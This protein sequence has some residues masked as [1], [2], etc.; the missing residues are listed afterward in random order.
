MRMVSRTTDQKGFTLIE[1]LIV[2]AIIGFLAAAVLVAVDPVKRIQDS[3]D[4]RRFSEANALLNAILTKQVDERSLLAGLAT[5][6]LIT[7]ST[8]A[9]VIVTDSTGIVCNAAAT[10]PGCNKTLDT[11][12]ANKNCVANIGGT[13]VGTA[14][15]SGTAVTGSGTDFDPEA[16]VGDVLLSASGGTCTVSAVG[17]DTGITCSN[18]PSPAFSGA[19]YNTSDSVVP[20]YIASIPIDPRGSG[21]TGPCISGCTTNG[22]LALG[23]TN[24]GYYIQRTRIEVGACSGEQSS[25]ISV[26]R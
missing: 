6:P 12:G 23:L 17:S 16:S 1:L 3:R 5:A 19:V 15:S 9:Q 11:S 14:T 21:T 24:S 25:T 26:K 13:M 2:I 8:N 10:R 22:D 4:A 7:S 20:N 18:T